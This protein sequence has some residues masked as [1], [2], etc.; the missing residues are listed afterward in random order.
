MQRLL[1]EEPENPFVVGVS[2]VV[3]SHRT[4]LA[5]PNVYFLIDSLPQDPVE[6][7]PPFCCLQISGPLLWWFRL[8]PSACCEDWKN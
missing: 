7:L 3:I 1:L 8:I 5:H 2:G 6:C 4:K